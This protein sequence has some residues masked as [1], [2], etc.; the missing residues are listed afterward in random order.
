[1]KLIVDNIAT[2]YTKD[3]SGKI[4]LML[5][6]WCDNLHT[7][8]KI[9]E[10]LKNDFT[11]VRLDLP[12]FGQTEK[13]PKTWNISD[14]SNF[15]K[16]FIDKL[17]I[18]PD[19]LLGHSFGGR[20]AI[21][22]ASEKIFKPKKIILIGSAGISKRLTIRN[23]LITIVTKIFGAITLLPPLFFYRNKIRKKLYQTIGSNYL[24]SSLLKETYIKVIS[25]DLKSNAKRIDI[26][27]KLIWG[28]NDTETPLKDAYSFESI[29]NKSSLRV[30]DNAGH[31]VHKEKPETVVSTIND[32]LN[33]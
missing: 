26:P 17:K 5:H 23:I 7:F 27:T 25:E 32:F 15:V 30:I 13:P 33:K 29:I 19:F 1:M 2:E 12:G 14:Y 4:V 18:N 10:T 20:I 3:G 9:T 28:E 8:D 22:G 21:K 31:M 16:S 11:V 6:G 24:D